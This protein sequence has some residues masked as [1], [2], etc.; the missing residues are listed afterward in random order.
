MLPGAV[1]LALLSFLLWIYL[2][3]RV[4]VVMWQSPENAGLIG[5]PCEPE[6]VVYWARTEPLR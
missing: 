3:L 1:V 2:E 6:V 5:N 4:K